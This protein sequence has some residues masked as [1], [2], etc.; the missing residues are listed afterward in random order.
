L[1]VP[2]AP[3]VALLVH[4]AATAVAAKPHYEIAGKVVKIA[5]GD[6]L[7]V[8]DA[9]NTQHK[10]RL[11]GIDAPEKAQPF[12][13]KAR[14]NLA[15]KV[16]GPGRSRRGIRSSRRVH[17]RGSRRTRASTRSV[18]RSES[19]VAAGMATDETVWK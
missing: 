1:R 4:I 16:F 12:G 5:D 6:T 10:I 3:I 19:N 14:E 17:G 18:G 2:F 7:T 13:T 15:G 8:L 9:S 11:A